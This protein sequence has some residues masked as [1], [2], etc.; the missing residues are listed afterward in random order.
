MSTIEL[1]QII[2]EYLSQIED[3]T[4]LNALKV[5]VES[6]VSDET[7]ILSDYQKNRIMEARKQFK[8]GQTMSN[9]SLHLEIDQWLNTK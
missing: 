1:R 6:K 7:Y 8:N 4:F 3:A 2:S 5:I 9:E